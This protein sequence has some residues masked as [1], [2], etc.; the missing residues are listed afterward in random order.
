MII[1]RSLREKDALD[2]KEA[3]LDICLFVVHPQCLCLSLTGKDEAVRERERQE[4]KQA[5]AAAAVKQG[6]GSRAS[7]GPVT[8][9]QVLHLFASRRGLADLELY[10]LKEADGDSYR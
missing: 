5:A 10:Y 8:A 7:K 1:Q 2:S 9:A 3:S 4:D 6:R